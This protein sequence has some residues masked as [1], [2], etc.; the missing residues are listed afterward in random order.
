MAA[1][2]FVVGG[3]DEYL[4]KHPHIVGSWSEYVFS[5]YWIITTITTTGYG[6]QKETERERGKREEQKKCTNVFFYI[7]K[8]YEQQVISHQST[9]RRL[10]SV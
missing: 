10:C 3:M 5:V 6:R 4:R 8:L 1:L 7:E 9:V 2:W